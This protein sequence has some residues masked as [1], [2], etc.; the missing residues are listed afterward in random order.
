MVLYYSWFCPPERERGTGVQDVLTIVNKFSIRNSLIHF[1][2][3]QRSWGKVIF[4]EAC[5]KNSVHGGGYAWQGG[6]H[7]QGACMARGACVAG[8]HAWGA[9]MAGGM[10]GRGAC[11]WWGPAWQGDR[12]VWQGA[13]WGVGACMAGGVH[14]MH[15]SQTL[16]DTVGHC[17]GGTH[18]TGM[19]SCL[20]GRREGAKEQASQI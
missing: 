11:R 12:P 7:V 10:H 2:R 19:H 16:R 15:T 14:A 9:C 8:K 4:S 20:V 5:V 13:W 18:H 3:P 6:M 17:T 1:Y